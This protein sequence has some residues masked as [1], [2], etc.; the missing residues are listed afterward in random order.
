MK[1]ITG[2]NIGDGFGSQL[3][4]KIAG[5]TYAKY[6]GLNYLYNP[7]SGIIMI[8][9]PDQSRN[10]EL[11][12][13]NMMLEK[14]MKKLDVENISKIDKTINIESHHRTFFY[15]QILSNPNQYFNENILKSFQ[16]SYTQEKPDYYKEKN[17][18]IAI[19]IRRGNDIESN[20]GV[21]YINSDLYDRIIEILLQ[22]IDNSIIHI[23]SWNDPEINIKSDRVVYHITNDGGEEFI[24]DF[25]GLVHADILLVGSSTFSLSAGFFNKN[26]VLCSKQIFKLHQNGP[27]PSLWER[28]FEN[29][30][31]NF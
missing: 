27:F 24:S 15:N 21:R 7:I 16:E 14:I 20:D 4:A 8:D 3:Y 26:T 25:N 31:G 1:Y 6:H 19:H 29:I 2:D 5:V 13:V 22:K 28:N 30:I 23:F 11:E 10:S 9:K 12:S 18:N 17:V